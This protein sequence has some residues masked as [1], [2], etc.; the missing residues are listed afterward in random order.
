MAFMRRQALA[1]G[2][3]LVAVTLFA[4]PARDASAFDYITNGGF[5][6]GS[7]AWSA[8]PNV[9]LD[10]ITATDVT[11][12]EGEFAARI[13]LTSGSVPAAIRQT[14]WSGAPAGVYHLSAW[15]RTTS[16]ATEISVQIIENP[17]SRMLRL[18]SV[19][20]AGRWA[21][22]EGDID[23]VGFSNLVL[24]V[25]AA[26]AA[27]DVIYIDDVRLEGQPPATMTP[28]ATPTPQPSATA[29]PTATGTRT[30]TATRTPSATRTPLATKTPR[31]S[32]AA[33]IGPD[34]LNGSFED[35]GPDGAP[36]GWQKYGGALDLTTG[37]THGGSQA[38]VLTSATDSTKWLYQT[39][40]VESGASYAF[41]AW[42][43]DDD[44]G[45][46]A[47]RSPPSIQPSGSPRQR[48]TIAI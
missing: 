32:A 36:I 8:W 12:V 9:Q 46:A 37:T 27:G 7:G 4:A 28:T 29:T 33:T 43:V 25:G 48:R 21:R 11:P 35:T 42:I 16:P 44:S 38:A 1:I 45:V 15:V 22:V 17:S 23:I 5:E 26:G 14:S 13:T 31:P 30:P 18:S 2:I 19:G 3:A 34:L 6:S 24:T 20:P 39:V 47:R 40:L 41:S 10:I